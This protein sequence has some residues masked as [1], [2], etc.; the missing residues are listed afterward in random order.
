MPDGL[1]DQP[2]PPL[3]VAL[4]NN[5]PD[6]AVAVTERQFRT[7]AQA[8]AP[9]RV[10]EI[11]PFEIPGIERT[12]AIRARMAA[13]YRPIEALDEAAPDLLIVTGADPGSK[14]LP[15]NAF[16]PGFSRL[17]DWA[18]DRRQPTL[19]SCLAAHAAA[20]RLDGVPR[21]K[22][23]LKM[24]GVFD[25]RPADGG[26]LTRGLEAG[27]AFP[28]SHYN[29]V[30]EP[31]LV[32]AGYRLISRSPVAGVDSFTRGDDPFL[33]LQG[34]P[35]YDHD[36]LALEF[37]RDFRA[38]VHGERDSLPAVPANLYPAEVEQ[39]L[40]ALRDEALSAPSPELLARW[41]REDG[42]AGRPAPW[43]AAAA[44]LVANWLASVLAPVAREVS[45]RP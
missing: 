39:A 35:E 21:H 44:R 45:R 29:D 2:P 11:L 24:S 41:P 19:W 23:G 27:W 42:L 26:R 28:H 13:R 9:D 16:W 40:A 36:S 31:D 22:L 6:A 33:F 15:E 20:W 4:V 7:L 5:M 12:E 18:A 3:R 1:T 43:R 37:R 25:C 8:A 14:P 10:V 30:I 17:I 32:A 38:F 34:H